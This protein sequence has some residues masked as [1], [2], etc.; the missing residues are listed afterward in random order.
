MNVE[1]FLY[2]CLV[3]NNSETNTNYTVLGMLVVCIKTLKITVD[4]VY[5]HMVQ[6]KKGHVLILK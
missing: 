1:V 6:L 5:G 3:L 4:V 2:V